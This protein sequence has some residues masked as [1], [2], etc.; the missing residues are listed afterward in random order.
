M[1]LTQI[2]YRKQSVENQLWILSLLIVLS[3][4]APLA[5]DMFLPA[6]PSMASQLDISSTALQLCVTLFLLA[7]ASSQL[8]YGPCSDRFGRR[9]VLTLGLF[10]FVLGGIVCV[11]ANGEV[12]LIVG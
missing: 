2:F 6:M 10:L 11:L 1:N 3:A 4:I 12:M 7:F 9:P 8:I 5:V